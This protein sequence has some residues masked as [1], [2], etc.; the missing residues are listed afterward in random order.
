MESGDGREL[1]ALA[2][3]LP[4]DDYLLLQLA[5]LLYEPVTTGFLCRSFIG[6]GHFLSDEQRL[7]TEEVRGIVERLRRQGL[8]TPENRC[9][10]VLAE[11]LLRAAAEEKR[12][13]RLLAFVEQSTP[14]EYRHGRWQLRC[15]RALRRFRIGIYSKNSDLVE[16]TLALLQEQ[17]CRQ[18]FAGMPP[19]VQILTCAFDPAWFAALPAHLRFLLLN[20]LIHVGIAHLLPLPAIQAYLQ[21]DADRQ[22]GT[23][24][25]LPFLRLLATWYLV[26]G[27]TAALA[28][29]LDTH[30]G[31][32]TGSGLRAALVFQQGDTDRA[33]A[34]FRQDLDF[35]ADLLGEK[36][37]VFPGLPGI[38]SVLVLLRTGE[39]AAPAAAR[40]SLARMQKRC[41]GEMAE[42]LPL[43]SLDAYAVHLQGERPD[44]LPLGSALTHE[45]HPLALLLA[46]LVF[47]WLGVEI[48]P[49]FI[50]RL[51]RVQ[52]RAEAGGFAWI[53]REAAALR[54]ALRKDT[55][56]GSGSSGDAET[57]VLS[58][59]FEPAQDWQQSLDELIAAVHAVRRTDSDRRLCWF[60][61]Y[62]DNTLSL[63]AR[64]QRRND[65]GQ[66]SVGRNLA[67]SRL[68]STDQPYFTPQDQR[69]R[70][71]LVRVAEGGGASSDGYAFDQERA[72]PALIGHPLVFLRHSPRT[73]V[74][75]VAAEPELMVERRGDF[76]FLSFP[77]P[78]GA[79]SVCVWPETATR[80]RVLRIREEHRRVAAITGT[81]G[82]RVPLSA[83]AEVLATIGRLASFMTVHSA[84]DMP[85]TGESLESVPGD[86]TPHIHIIPLGEGFRIELFV[87]PF[88]MQG[89]YIKPGEG[90]A[91]LIAEIEGRRLRARRDL[92]LEE[93]RAR[94]VEESCPMLDLAADMEVGRRHE[95]HLLAPEDCLQVLLELDAI[96]DRV[97]LEW[98]EGNKLSIRR[99]VGTAQLNLNIRGLHQDWFALSGQVRIDEAQVVELCYLL[100]RA[101]QSP[102]RFIPLGEGQFLALTQEFRNHLDELLYYGS[103]EGSG[104]KIRVHALAAMALDE[105]GRRADTRA[106]AAW[107][108]RQEE[109]GAV[110]QLCPAVPATLKAELRDYQKE[111][112]VW[113]SRM[114][115]LGLGAC[116]ADDM[117]LGKTLQ[118]LALILS[119]AKDGPTLV[120]APTSVCMNWQA[121]IRR[122]APT[123]RLRQPAELRQDPEQEPAAFEVFVCSYTLLQQEE[124]A[125]AA[126]VWQTIVLDEAQAI[127]NAATK[128]SQAA[129]RLQAAFRLITTGTPIENHLG[130]LWNLFAFINPGLLGSLK[131]FNRRFGVPIE[132][133][134]DKAARKMLKKLIRPFILRRIKAE[135]LDELPPRTEVNLRVELHQEERSFYEALRRQALENIEGDRVRSDRQIRILTEI[136]RLRRACCNPRLVDPGMEIA[137]SKEQVFSELVDE[138]IGAGHRALVFSQFTGHLRLLRQHLD[139]RQIGYCYLDGSTA[140]AQRRRQVEAFQSGGAPLFLISLK[141]GGLGLNLTAA[142]Y[143]I[144]MDPW[145]NPAV[146]DQAADRAHRIGQKRPVTVYR[147]VSADTIEEKIVRLHH[148]K[149]DLA[150][151]LLEGTNV[152]ARISAEELLE[153]IRGS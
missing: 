89:P 52:R 74:E 148:A 69:L 77:H 63:V 71:A 5:A 79:E 92:D 31:F 121:E 103:M 50:D 123:L 82:L 56:P 98:P 28:R 78:L 14:M 41:G 124:K 91:N 131:Q 61:N 42:M 18:L 90:A 17:A 39:E 51:E 107:H 37:P 59:L 115:T 34:L 81:R 85:G 67:L 68:A 150:D 99:Q 7:R 145:W 49:A 46:L 64:E 26:R 83:S 105:L 57:P 9:P 147:L 141:A 88:T 70:A 1:L 6:L 127:K 130:E 151:S 35:L 109:I 111:G 19:T 23:A 75:I 65:R 146:E 153:L 10:P 139:A 53:A 118:A 73:P 27:E 106:E 33:G 55:A 13:V 97:V 16:E 54:A 128:R 32:F 11:L 93:A 137:S 3:S 36:T 100:D 24:E 142:D 4:D 12:F 87:R 72:L 21:Q 125:L 104:R 135:V 84:I 149:R 95:W 101:R 58:R 120:V 138:L 94:E 45:E 114:A 140:A 132:K 29:L 15:W 66:W 108:R 80:F 122:F 116:L 112:F 113:L 102:G 119:R 47:H 144:H 25:Q 136:M 20:H 40:R 117:G 96:R 134:R 129:M 43:H 62:A 76:L 152:S 110:W 86:A 48:A 8:L 133:H 2:R 143:V 44:L 30:E 126:I 60:V 22:P 38:F